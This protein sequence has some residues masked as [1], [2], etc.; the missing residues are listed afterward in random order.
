VPRPIEAADFPAG[1]LLSREHHPGSLHQSLKQQQGEAPLAAVTSSAPPISRPAGHWRAFK[2]HWVVYVAGVLLPL[3]LYCIFVGY[4]LVYNVYLSF[5][6]WNGL[7][8]HMKFVGFSN[9][10]EL[11]HDSI[12]WDSLTNTLRWVAGA[13]IFADG[14]A[15]LLAVFLRSNK[16]HLGTA[17]RMLFFLPVTMSL[18]S[19]SLMFSFILNPAFGVI[20]V[21]L[22]DIGLGSLNVDL[23]GNSSSAIYTL[24]AVFG[25]SYVGIPMMLFDAG[26]TQIPA[27]LYE[28]ARLEGA[29][30]AQ[31]LFRVTMPILRPIF[32]VV[33]ILA[34]IEALRTF[35]IVLVMTRGGPGTASDVLGYFMYIAAFTET[36]FGYGAAIS[37]VILLF[38]AVFALT[39]LRRVG[40]DVLHASE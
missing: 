25:W 1:R 24:I 23:L 29:G 38:S 21:I 15:F 20:S 40:R 14:V 36:R 33:T 22:Q 27:E 13:I 32:L 10:T 30:T 9:Y 37:T 16:V 11:F 17:L 12:F 6:D 5:V 18:V 31:I 7:S 28:A 8:A 39:Y 4:P 26:L 34:V 19:I 2:K 3:I 35:D